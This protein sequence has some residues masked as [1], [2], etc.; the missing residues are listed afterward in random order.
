MSEETQV[1]DEVDH[2]VHECQNCGEDY[3][4]TCPDPAEV[5]HIAYCSKCFDELG[6]D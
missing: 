4:C 3:H 1:F 2:H 6:S 5:S